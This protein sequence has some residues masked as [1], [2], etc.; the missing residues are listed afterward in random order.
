MS[1]MASAAMTEWYTHPVYAFHWGMNINLDCRYPQT[2]ESPVPGSGEECAA[3]WSLKSEEL[4]H[5]IALPLLARCSALTATC[6]LETS[7][8]TKR[9]FPASHTGDDSP[10]S[11]TLS[12]PIWMGSRRKHRRSVLRS[13]TC[14]DTQACTLSPAGSPTP[15]KPPTLNLEYGITIWATNIRGR[16]QAHNKIHVA[17]S[18]SSG[19]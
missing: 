17:P 5:G 14:G 1:M 10:S 13:S 15:S 8:Y 9:T 11:M 2:V 7:T 6:G 18:M 16:A 4:S 19:S 12:D 3:L